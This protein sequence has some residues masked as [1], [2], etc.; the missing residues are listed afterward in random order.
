[1][2]GEQETGLLLRYAT[3]LNCILNNVPT[4]LYYICTRKA[5]RKKENLLVRRHIIVKLN[6]RIEKEQV[7]IVLET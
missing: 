2:I 1:M 4:W 3:G 7:S 6:A 5:K